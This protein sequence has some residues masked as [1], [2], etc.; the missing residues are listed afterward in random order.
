M[1]DADRWCEYLTT[2][3]QIAGPLTENDWLLAIILSL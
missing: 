2:E 3:F 1:S